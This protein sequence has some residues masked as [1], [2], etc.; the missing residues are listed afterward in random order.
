MKTVLWHLFESI[1]KSLDCLG[2]TL[3]TAFGGMLSIPFFQTILCGNQQAVNF[4]RGKR[5]G[6]FS[7]QRISVVFQ[8]GNATII[9]GII[10]VD[11]DVE[12]F[13]ALWVLPLPL[14]PFNPLVHLHIF[15]T[16]D[17]GIVCCISYV[18]WV[19]SCR[20]VYYVSQDSDINRKLEKYIPYRLHRCA[21]TV[22]FV[23]AYC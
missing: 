16:N 21:C 7:S 4:S 19:Y 22:N 14:P 18:S 8:R 6:L 2:P 11:S 13:D 15:F 1:V 17:N 20:A 10:P 3:I 12:K 9:L 5:T 23:L